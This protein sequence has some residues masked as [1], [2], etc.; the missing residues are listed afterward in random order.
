MNPE[1]DLETC[2]R[3]ASEG[4]AMLDFLEDEKLGDGGGN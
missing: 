3:T 4:F 2:D 1:G